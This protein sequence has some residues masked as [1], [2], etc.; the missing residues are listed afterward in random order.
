MYWDI[1]KDGF[2]TIQ[3]MFSDLAQASGAAQRVFDL[4]DIQPDIPL[5]QG[6]ELL[7]SSFLGDIVFEDVH[8]SY[9]T[10]PDKQ[11][12]NGLSLKVPGG[13]TCALVGRSGAGKSTIMHLLLRFYDP[14]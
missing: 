2:D 1:L 14:K 8:F 11:V 7:R 3:D 12:L 9:Q 6:T 13:G 10:R 4:L 5:E